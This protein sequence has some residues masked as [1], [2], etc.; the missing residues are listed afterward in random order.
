MDWKE[1]AIIDLILCK[2]LKNLISFLILI[3][4]YNDI[5]FII[6]YLI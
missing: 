3:L 2:I 1:S 4:L 5:I 6:I